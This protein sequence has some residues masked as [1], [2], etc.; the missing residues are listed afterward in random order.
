MRIRKWENDDNLAVAKLEQIC[1]AY[2]W[3]EQMVKETAQMQNFYGVVAE[4]DGEVVG[5]AG[6]IIA[7]DVADI[8]LVAV[9]PKFRKKGIAQ[10]MLK[11][12]Q[13]ALDKLEV[14]SLFLEVRK[15]NESAI[16]LYTKFGFMPVGIRAKYYEDS[17]DAIV[18][19][20]V[21]EVE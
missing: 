18:M 19:L 6:A 10:G 17:E 9:A 13:D 8:A 2:P 15:S 4:I 12:L 20:K 5:Y 14:A 21:I 11:S 16:N 3:T 7:Y 1:F